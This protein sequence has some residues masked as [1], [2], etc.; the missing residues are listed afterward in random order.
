MYSKIFKTFLVALT[1]FGMSA[2][3][4]NEINIGSAN[5]G[6][7]DCPDGNVVYVTDGEARGEAA[8]VEFSG[9]RT[10]DL[11]LKTSK[12]VDGEVSA[13]LTYDPEV[14]AEYN[15][16]NG[17]DYKAFPSARV[18]LADGGRMSIAQGSLTSGAMGVTFTSDGSLD[19]HE[20]MAVPFRVSVTGGQAVSGQ[21]GYLM[22]VQDCTAFPGAEKLY[23]GKPGMKIVG[24]IEVNDV[25]PLNVAGFTLKESGKQFFDVVVL[26][27]A[28]INFNS[29]TGR[30]YISRNENVQALLDQRDKYI[31]PL[32]DRGIKVVLG[33]LGNHDLSGIS[34][35]GPELARRF[36]GE[37][38][39][40]CDAYGLDG[41]FLDDE[42]TDYADAASGRLPGFVAQSRKAASQLAYEIRKAQPSRLLLCYRYLA[43]YGGVEIDGTQ[44]G[45]VWDYVLNDYWE[46]SDPTSTFAGL[47]QNQAGT[48]SWNCSSYNLCLPSTSR[49][50]SLFSLT[51]M[52]DAGYGALM[53]FNFRCDPGYQHTNIIIKDM[54]QTAADFWESTLEYDGKWYPKDF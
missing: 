19:P 47:R 18:S 39:N 41:V 26:F 28:N 44:P 23:K 3:D 4:K 37:V 16:A 48:G 5:T 6:I 34:T 14:L 8:Y 42:Y 43:L 20:V 2:C 11:F 50:K 24:V 29:Q 54:N 36:A 52:R 10:V 46:T 32:Q 53:I 33:I 17:T 12:S 7:L 13:V 15:K 1:A 51:G 40:V 27:S 38:R 31:K 49:W 30:V 35:L 22:L 45:S 9:T 25:N 21:T